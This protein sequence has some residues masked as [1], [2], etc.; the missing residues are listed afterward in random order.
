MY[1]IS[2][3]KTGFCVGYL[4]CTTLDAPLISKVRF[5]CKS[6]IGRRDL[7]PLLHEVQQKPAELSRGILSLKPGMWACIVWGESSAVSTDL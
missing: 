5:E 6:I 1:A 4:V 3:C 7:G 2:S